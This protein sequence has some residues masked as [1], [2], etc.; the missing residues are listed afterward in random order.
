MK[1]VIDIIRKDLKAAARRE[2]EHIQGPAAVLDNQ[3]RAFAKGNAEDKAALR[4][5]IE[6]SIT[7]INASRAGR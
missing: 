4:P 6:K 3:L 2:P 5:Q 1:S 7:K